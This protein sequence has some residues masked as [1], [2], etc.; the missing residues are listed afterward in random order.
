MAIRCQVVEPRIVEPQIVD[1]DHI[2][3]SRWSDWVVFLEGL[4]RRFVPLR[5][6]RCGVCR[7]R[8]PY[9]EVGRVGLMAV[10][11]DG[12]P[13]IVRVT[14]VR[15]SSQKVTRVVIPNVGLLFVRGRERLDGSALHDGI[16]HLECTETT[17]VHPRE[18]LRPVTL[19]ELDRLW[20]ASPPG[21]T[22]YLEST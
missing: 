6:L 10:G 11:L 2:G 9:E 18:P 13:W 16:A 5:E 3:F 22:I 7:R 15:S 1:G 4:N 17:R 8:R 19:A 12:R 21:G 14:R 20:K